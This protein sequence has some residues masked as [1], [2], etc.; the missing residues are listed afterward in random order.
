LKGAQ[1]GG[2]Y[3][4]KALGYWED[5]CVSVSLRPRKFGEVDPVE[6][7]DLSPDTRVTIPHYAYVGQRIDLFHYPFIISSQK[8]S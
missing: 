3:A 4:A 6:I 7:W 5:E 1:F 2:F 8:E